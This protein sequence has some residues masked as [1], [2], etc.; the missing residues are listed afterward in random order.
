MADAYINQ[1]ATDLS[2]VVWSKALQFPLRDELVFDAVATPRSTTESGTRGKSVTVI[3]PDDLAVATTE[4]NEVTNP[5]SVTISDTTLNFPL[6]EQG[7]TVKTTALARHTGMVP[8]QDV[9]LN[10]LGFNAGS[11]LDTIAATALAASTNVLYQ[12]SLANN[13]AITAA[14]TLTTKTLEIAKTKLRTRNVGKIN[15]EYWLYAHPYQILDLRLETGAGSWRAP[16]E[17]GGLNGYELVSGDEGGWAGFRIISTN[18][19]PMTADV[20]ASSTVDVYSAIAVGQDA[21]CKAYSDA[22]GAPGPNPQVIFGL[23][24][25]PMKRTL[26][27]SWYHLVGYKIMRA[28]AVQKINTA[29]SL[30]ANT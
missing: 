13:A 28:A 1:A 22:P 3:F 30:G 8:V 10:L 21:L 24:T 9:A 15:S 4:L 2:Q 23:P 20:G 18:R 6:K 26:P 19:D 29:A 7:N 11:S 5:D 14:K 16:R 27:I 25:D 17:G 12:E